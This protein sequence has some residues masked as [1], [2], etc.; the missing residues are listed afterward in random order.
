MIW[1]VENF[2]PKNQGNVREVISILVWKNIATIC[3]D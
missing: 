2:I 1:Y 3:I